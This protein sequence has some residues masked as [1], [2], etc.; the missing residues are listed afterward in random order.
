MILF[1]LLSMFVLVF[2]QDPPRA[3]YDL[4]YAGHLDTAPRIM[5]NIMGIR[6][7]LSAT[8]V[9]SDVL[10]LSFFGIIS[11]KLQTSWVLKIRLLMVFALGTLSFAAAFK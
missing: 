3:G 4:V 11:W 1:A 8:H 10:F 5:M 2:I 9:S 7:T 6:Y